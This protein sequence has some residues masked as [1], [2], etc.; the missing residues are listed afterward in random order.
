MITVIGS[1]N[2]D[3]VCYAERIP[4]LGETVAGS[5]FL[6]AAGG[7]G[8]NQA[9]AA[10]RLGADTTLLTKLGGEDR[11][12]GLLTDG[13]KAAGV[14]V[15][16]I[17]FVPGSYCG[18]ALIMVDRQAHNII[19][20]VPNANACINAAYIDEN[21]PLIEASRVLIVEFGV[22]APAVE[23]AIA[24]ARHAGVMTLVNPAPAR[25]VKDAFY[26]NVDIIVPN[27]T[28]AEALTGLRLCGPK[29]L[30][31]AAR[32][33]H[34]RDAERVVITLG[35][36]GVFVSDGRRSTLIRGHAVKT[37][38]TTGAGDAFI[39]GLA[40]ALAEGRDIFEAALFANAAAALSVTR[41]GAAQSMPARPD[42]DA[43]IRAGGSD[44]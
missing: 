37:V 8:A 42:V 24:M 18:C 13:F 3:Y 28:E 21:R 38:D 6:V 15:S 31:D 30:K 41:P 40:C 9:V 39:G 44:G 25:P 29:D 4:C 27:E 17:G 43:F 2:I 11:Y 16:R 7:K 36:K 19:G 34:D 1:A 5:V 12:A 23:Y 14:D 22:P 35:E 26:G 32:F 20:I 33:F 10:A